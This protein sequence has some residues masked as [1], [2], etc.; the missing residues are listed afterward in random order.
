VSAG[1]ASAIVIAASATA[2]RQGQSAGARATVASTIAPTLSTL[3]S[4]ATATAA[5]IV[6]RPGSR[7][8]AWIAISG[9][10]AAA[11]SSLIPPHWA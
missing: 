3:S 4:A 10:S 7:R 2:R 9:R 11:A 8:A 5:G 6:L 1:N